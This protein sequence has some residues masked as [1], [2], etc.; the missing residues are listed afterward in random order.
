MSSW[1]VRSATSSFEF[2]FP[3]AA[4]LALIYG[5]TLAFLPLE[6]FLD[7]ANY[8]TYAAE[9]HIILAR[10]WERGLLAVLSNEPLWLFTNIALHAIMPAEWVLRTIIFVP[11]C[12]V[13]YTVIKQ[14]P[15]QII[16][17]LLFLLMTQVLKNHIIHLRQ[18]YAV[19]LFLAGWLAPQKRVG[20]TLMLGAAFV[21]TSFAFVLVILAV[22][23]LAK[24]LRLDPYLQV[25]T[26]IFLG[27][28]VGVALPYIAAAVGARQAGEYDFSAASVSGL[29]F[30]FWTAM[31]FMFLLAG[32][33]FVAAHAFALANLGFYLATYFQVEVTARIF[34]STLL[35]VL[36]S[37]L[38]LKEWRRLIFLAATLC[39]AVLQYAQRA[40]LP[41]LGWGV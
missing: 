14:Y 22:V 18:G 19:A 20:R 36:F 5:T 40:D 16:W 28:V 15:R 37:G 27:A 10:Y 13:A 6:A 12:S 38:D 2:R 17:L 26:A 41:Y 23:R 21:H 7:R 39:Y 24:F 32:R 30:V 31:M 9:S 1:V 11:A 3:S 35:F 33:T 29:S 34:E 4:L 8:L 25:S